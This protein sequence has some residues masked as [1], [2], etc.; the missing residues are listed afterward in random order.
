MP[1]NEEFI[2]KFYEAFRKKDKDTYLGMCHENIEWVTMDGM[3]N[4][5]KYVGVKEIFENYF[6]NMLSNF[7]EFHATPDTFI[8]SNDHII[9]IGRY[10]GISKNEKPFEVPFSHVYKITDNK[11]TNF[12]QFT[13]TKKIQDSLD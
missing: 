9:V 3:P 12:R 2:K 10:H 5:G 7:K 1:S 4:G 6:P 8:D 11:I 13:D